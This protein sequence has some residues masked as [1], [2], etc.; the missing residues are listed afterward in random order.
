MRRE[1]KHEKS[2]KI[3]GICTVRDPVV[4]DGLWLRHANSG[5]YLCQNFRRDPGTPAAHGICTTSTSS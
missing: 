2:K 1:D 5:D 4:S 3:V